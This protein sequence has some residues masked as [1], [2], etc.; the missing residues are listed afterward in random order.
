[1][2]HFSPVRSNI[3][4]MPGAMP[5]QSTGKVDGIGAISPLAAEF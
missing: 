2:R 1:M 4:E 3:C 5:L